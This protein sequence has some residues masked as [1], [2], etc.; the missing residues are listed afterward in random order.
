C[1]TLRDQEFDHDN[2]VALDRRLDKLHIYSFVPTRDPD[3]YPQI[4][5]SSAVATSKQIQGMLNLK[6]TWH[7]DIS[8]EEQPVDPPFCKGKKYE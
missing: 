2:Q 7:T 5:F 1:C 4:G 6:G 3:A 8:F